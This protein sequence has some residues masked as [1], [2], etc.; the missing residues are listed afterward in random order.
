V[1]RRVWLAARI[2]DVVQPDGAV[3][4]DVVCLDLLG[5]G[6]DFEDVDAADGERGEVEA[7]APEHLGAEVEDVH[8]VNAGHGGHVWQTADEFLF[9]IGCAEL[10]G[11]PKDQQ[12]VCR[13]W[14]L[15]GK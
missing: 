11:G 1:R 5:D 4:F 9:S 15:G 10:W 6:V 13:N 14:E 7:P 8:G 2:T 12:R 3:E